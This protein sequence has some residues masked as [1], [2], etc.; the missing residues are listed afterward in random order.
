MVQSELVQ[1]RRMHVVDM[2]RVPNDVPAKFVRLAIDLP[3]T[4]ATA[5]K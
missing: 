2:N 3:T 1:Q 4:Y 5:S